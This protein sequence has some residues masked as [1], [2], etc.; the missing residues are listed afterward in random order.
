MSSDLTDQIL[1]R[2]AGSDHIRSESESNR[3]KIISIKIR[4]KQW[5]LFE[6]VIDDR[7]L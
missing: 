7:Y 2:S 5:N 3:E 4:R 6:Y 1:I